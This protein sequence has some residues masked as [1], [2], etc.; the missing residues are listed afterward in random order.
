MTLNFL[1]TLPES[2]STGRKGQ[3]GSASGERQGPL[4]A[5]VA[6]HPLRR[7]WL[8]LQRCRHRQAGARQRQGRDGH[9]RDSDG[10]RLRCR[11]GPGH[12]HQAEGR[13]EAE[14]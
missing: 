2:V 7:C 3:V 9:G 4:A 12:G 6:P 1:D 8:P 10:V 13:A 5:H 11:S 14:G